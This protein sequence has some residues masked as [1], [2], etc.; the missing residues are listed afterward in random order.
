MNTSILTVV[1]AGAVLAGQNGTPTWQNSYTAAQRMATE[2]QKPV[3]V[4]LGSG[5][6]GWTQM[7]GGEAPSGEVAQLLSKYVCCYIDTATPEGKMLAQRFEI[8]GPGMVISDRGCNYQAFWHQ[9]VLS[10]QDMARCL[11]RYSNPQMS[12]RTTETANSVRTSF[13][14][15]QGA[16][17]GGHDS[18]YGT[19]ITG[20]SYCPSC[21]NARRR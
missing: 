20:G 12:V 4:V 7:F 8:N 13:Y 6:N 10:Y 15:E 9:G 21:G 3:L 19:G 5:A 18:Y 14:P 16:G 1:L 11:V 2:Q 17:M